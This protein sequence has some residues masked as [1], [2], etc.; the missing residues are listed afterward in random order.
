MSYTNVFLFYPVLSYLIK[1][2]VQNSHWYSC[3]ISCIMCGKNDWMDGEIEC[4]YRHHG[5]LYSD[6]FRTSLFFEFSLANHCTLL[7]IDTRKLV[8]CAC[9]WMTNFESQCGVDVSRV[10]TSTLDE[11]STFSAPRPSPTKKTIKSVERSDWMD[12]W[13]GPSDRLVKI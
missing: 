8:E 4:S 6:I 10:L 2:D 5:A 1:V 13:I 12:Q 9:F 3:Y 7:P 11:V